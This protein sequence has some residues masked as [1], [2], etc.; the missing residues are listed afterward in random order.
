MAGR[1]GSRRWW[2]L[3]VVPAILVAACG[4]SRVSHD[5]I[6]SAVNGNPLASTPAQQHALRSLQARQG[7]VSTVPQNGS[8]PLTGATSATGAVGGGTAVGGA[9]AGG[10]ATTGGGVAATGTS[11]GPAAGSG[12]AAARPAGP[13]APVLLANVGTYSGPAGSSTAGTDTMTQ[14]WAQRTNAHG[15]IAGHP[16]QVFTADDGGDP[17]RSL[18]LVRD[19]VENKHVIAFIG[20]Q[21]PF[22]LQAQLPYLHAHNIPLIGGDNVTPTWTQDNLLFPVGTTIDE[23]VFGDMKVAHQRGLPK[24]AIVYCVETSACTHIHDYTMN[25]GASRAGEDVVY[26]SQVTITQPDYTAQCLGAK[27]AGAQVLHT[28][29][30]AASIRRLAASC[31][32]QNYHPIYFATAIQTTHDL[33]GDPDL[34]GFFAT[35]QD[36]P[37]MLGNTPATAEF[38]QAVQ[39]FAPNLR[40]SGG[41]AIA[42]AAGQLLAKA[43]ASHLGAQPT[44]QDILDGLWTV[45]NETLGGLTPP[46]TF[47]KG[48][49]TPPIACYYLIEL[50]DGRWAAPTGDTYAC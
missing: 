32:R 2:M 46:V 14:V 26:Q 47:V 15:G 37:Y 4:G 10:P 35:A 20:N 18:S 27:A 39:E 42:W 19:M 12:P 25:G 36:F 8:A 44:S 49:P 38:Q 6:V 23:A 45:K 24:M 30:E 48:Q 9:Q 1:G 34:E 16:V 50:K 11:H 31:A 22:T 21:V 13:L 28:V 7:A 33:E 29:L 5:A 41:T 17:E 3:A 43:V 40:L